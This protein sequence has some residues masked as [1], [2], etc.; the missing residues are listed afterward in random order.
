MTELTNKLPRSQGTP[1]YNLNALPKN[2]IQGTLLEMQ[3]PVHYTVLVYTNDLRVLSSHRILGSVRDV[4]FSLLIQNAIMQVLGASY[5]NYVLP[6]ARLTD[7]RGGYI[8]TPF[9]T[10]QF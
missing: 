2:Y 4:D 6:I 9:V 10:F 8:L 7:M 5:R 3:R 1:A